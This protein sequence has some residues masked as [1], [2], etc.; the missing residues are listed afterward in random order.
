MKITKIG[1]VGKTQDFPE[2]WMNFGGIG[3]VHIVGVWDKGK[4]KDWFPHEWPPR[5]MWVI[6]TDKKPE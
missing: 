4:K 2:I 3:E 5:K 1:W 6:V